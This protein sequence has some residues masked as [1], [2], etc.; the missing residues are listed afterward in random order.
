MEAGRAKPFRNLDL[1]L[2]FI[3]VA[4]KLI[5]RKPGALR[6]AALAERALEKES[7]IWV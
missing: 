3:P 1:N 7:D 5:H 2:W 4:K 6:G